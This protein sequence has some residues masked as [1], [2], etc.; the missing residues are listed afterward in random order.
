MQAA[1]SLGAR[2]L[3]IIARD[4]L[5]PREMAESARDAAMRFG[6]AAGE[7]ELHDA[8]T[9]DYALQIAKARASGADAW[10]AFGEAR[11]A[12]EMVKSFKRLR[13]APRVFYARG[14]ADPKFIDYVGQ[15]AEFTLASVEYDT[16]LAT[17]GND[18][19]VKAFNARWSSRPGAPAA[20]GYSAAV[21][22]GEAIRRAGGADSAKLREVLASAE[23][24][25]V[26]GTYKVDPKTGEQIGTQPAL[27]QIVK[28]KPEFVSPTAGIRTVAAPYPQWSERHYAKKERR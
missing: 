12:A 9:E 23:I 4:D 27:V 7:V 5:V 20:E 14:A 2:T 22:L 6:L 26:L 25:T 11:D 15:D 1:K 8:G 19:F 10:L 13:F 21:V 28:G 16:R 18:R 24:P 17:P 3:F